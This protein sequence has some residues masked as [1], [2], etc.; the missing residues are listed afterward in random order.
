MRMHASMDTRTQAQTERQTKTQTHAHTHTP[1]TPHAHTHT[2]THA[3]TQPHTHTHTRARERARTPCLSISL[4]LSLHLSLCISLSL[5]LSLSLS[6]YPVFELRLGKPIGFCLVTQT[7]R[8]SISCSCI[9]SES[10]SD[11][12]GSFRV[13]TIPRGPYPTP[14]LGYLFFKIT[15]PNHKTRY[16]KKGVGY[17]PL[18][19]GPRIEPSTARSFRGAPKCSEATPEY[20]AKKTCKP[21]HILA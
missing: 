17:E 3:R 5:S 9:A 10:S 20:C 15:D 21:W 13:Q 2:Q 7:C 1:T 4:S 14:F 11:E 12:N 16:P 18:G 6:P 19:K 8:V